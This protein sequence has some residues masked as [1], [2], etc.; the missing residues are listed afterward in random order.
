MDETAYVATSPNGIIHIGYVIKQEKNL[1]ILL[2]VSVPR[3]K[4]WFSIIV[5]SMGDVLATLDA[6]KVA[7]TL[8]FVTSV[9]SQANDG[10]QRDIIGDWDKEIIV[11]CLAQVK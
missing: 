7:T 10:T 9:A 6:A 3:L 11:S 5:P 1:F 8:L 4:Q 2:L